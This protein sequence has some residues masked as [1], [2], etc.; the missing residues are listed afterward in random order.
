FISAASGTVNCENMHA[1]TSP[2][3]TRS[4]NTPSFI[5]P[6]IISCHDV[7]VVVVGSGFASFIARHSNSAA[8]MDVDAS[9]R[10]T[11]NHE[12][13]ASKPAIDAAI[14]KPRLIAQ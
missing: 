7:D 5:G 4:M 12:T 9:N 8:A 13:F 14:A 3:T 10:N 1:L 6:V 2:S 11:R